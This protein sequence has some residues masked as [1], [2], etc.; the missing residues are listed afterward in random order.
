MAREFSTV[1]VVGLG[2][3]GA[4]IVEVFARNGIDVVAVEISEP[5]L[6]RGRATLTRSTDRAVAKG[7]LAAADRDALHERVH[8]AAG[9]DALHSVDLVIEAVPEHLDLKQ[10]IFAELDRICRPETILATNTSS[11]S[12][13]EISVATTRPNQ[14]IGIHFFNPAPVMKLVE[15][16]RTVVTAPEV[17]ADVEALC[18]RLGKVDVTINDRAGFIANALLFGYLNHA[19]GMFESHY[20]TREDID[21]AMKL[22]CGLPMGPLALMD[23]I[24]LDTAYEILDTMYRRGGRDRRHAPVPLLKQMV[25]AGLLGRK[26]GRGFYTYE[27]PGSPVVVPDEATPL[28]TEAGLGDGARAIAKVGVV[29]SGTMATGIIEVFAKAGYEVVSVTRGME[30][31]AT[32]CEAVKTSLNKGVVRGK[33]TEADRDAALGR[34]SWSATLDHLADVDLVVEAVVEELSVKKALFASLDEICKPGVVLATTTSSLPVID[35]A[36]ATHRPADVVGLHFFNPAPVMPL[37]EVVRTIRTSPEATATARAVCA[38]LGKTAVV[39]GDR[40]GFIVNALLFPYL[41]DAVKMLEASYS[42]ADDI[43][44]AMKLGCGYPMGPF[45]LLDVVG[46]DVALAIQRELYLE[47]REPG[48]APAPLLEHLVTAGYLGRKT[49][50]GFRDHSHR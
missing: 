22:G 10:R 21:A 45:E 43:D 28:T 19:V 6:E 13:T 41:N 23:L 15:V 1:G 33:L 9:L 49:R 16:V 44:H 40:S 8:F 5:A 39:C 17:V 32:V 2:T 30:K 34:I 14:V 38:A 7:K 31:S 47:L 12:V 37:V 48:F 26:S 50:R 20:A 18:A 25:T 27:R 46:L 4:G 29:G 42:T 24:G 35:V 3:M 11:L 36:M